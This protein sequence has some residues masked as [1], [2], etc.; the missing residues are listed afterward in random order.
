MRTPRRTGRKTRRERERVRSE[1]IK[2]MLGTIPVLRNIE[3]TLERWAGGWKGR[4]EMMDLKTR[5]EME[6]ESGGNSKE[7]QTAEHTG[8]GGECGVSADR[9]GRRKLSKMTG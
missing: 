4:H 3:A 9:L 5:D 6:E 1:G 2:Q 7:T 8:G